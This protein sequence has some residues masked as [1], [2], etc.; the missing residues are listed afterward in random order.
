M[1]D[2]GGAGAEV[3]WL[4]DRPAVHSEVRV[5]HQQ[6][7]SFLQRMVLLLFLALS[8]KIRSTSSHNGASLSGDTHKR[9]L[10]PSLISFSKGL[11]GFWRMDLALCGDLCGCVPV[12]LLIM[13]PFHLPK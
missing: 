12:L 3:R 7:T 9:F 1:W 11:V 6:G 10:F 13:Q 4:L 5:R 2:R 8:L